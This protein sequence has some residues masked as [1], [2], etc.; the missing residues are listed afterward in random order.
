MNNTGREIINEYKNYF[1]RSKF[2]TSEIYMSIKTIEDIRSYENCASSN[3]EELEKLSTEYKLY[4]SSYEEFRLIMGKF[5]LA[6]SKTFKLGIGI[7][8][9]QKFIDKFLDFN[10]RFEDLERKNIMKD[11]YVWK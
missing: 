5:A 1:I 4:D 9:K 6:L 8:D 11:A 10:T 7:K 3:L 2:N